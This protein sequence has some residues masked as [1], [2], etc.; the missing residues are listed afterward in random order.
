GSVLSYG[1]LAAK[2]NSSARAVGN[3]CRKN[4]LP[5][6]VPCHRVVAKSGIG[7]YS[8]QTEGP[9]IEQKRRLLR[10]EGICL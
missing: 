2:L 8:G 7:G 9:L 3:A 5:I 10:H 4:P 1:E 6:I